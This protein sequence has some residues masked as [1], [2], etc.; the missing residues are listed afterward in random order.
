MQ[1]ILLGSPSENSDLFR[2][3]SGREKVGIS[4]R[5]QGLIYLFI[6]PF[7]LVDGAGYIFLIYA[8]KM[9][10]SCFGPT[11]LSHKPPSQTQ[12]LSIQSAFSPD[13]KK[14]RAKF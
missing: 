7:T 12:P 1:N 8:F 14:H 2:N 11:V 10:L 6:Y 3:G 5:S 9:H 4:D 13:T